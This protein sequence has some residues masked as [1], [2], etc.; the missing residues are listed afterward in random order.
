MVDQDGLYL[1]LYRSNH[2]AFGTD[3][4]LPGGT[5]EGNET[6]L[7]SMLREVREETGVAIDAGSAREVY[8]GTD[9]AGPDWYYALFVVHVDSRPE[10]TISWEHASYEWLDHDSFILK[11]KNA[12]DTYMHMVYDVLK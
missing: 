6:S 4:D 1:L 11:A 7:E 9:Y 5:V 12:K 10:I 2:P 8:A 3:P